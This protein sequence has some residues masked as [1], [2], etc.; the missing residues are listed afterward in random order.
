MIDEASNPKLVSEEPSSKSKEEPQPEAD[1][2]AKRTET[3]PKVR[4][5][6]ESNDSN[7]VTTIES[8]DEILK[9]VKNKSKEPLKNK[10]RQTRTKLNDEYGSKVEDNPGI[11][12]SCNPANY[13]MKCQMTH[14][15]RSWRE[16]TEED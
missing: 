16:L 4:K 1:S 15:M 12:D 7:L 2:S 11:K 13:W 5:S 6:Q 10:S 3:K 9:L 8:E 14:K